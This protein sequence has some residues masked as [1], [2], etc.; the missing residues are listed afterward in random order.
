MYL[1]FIF[2]V[3]TSASKDSIPFLSVSDL[4]LTSAFSVQT[5]FGW[6][7]FCAGGADEFGPFEVLTHVIRVCEPLEVYDFRMLILLLKPPYA[8]PWRGLSH[9]FGPFPTL[10]HLFALIFFVFMSIVGE[11]TPF[12]VF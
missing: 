8:V 4:D 11:S 2:I 7:M 3:E 9:L 12:S 5:S 6:L 1:G 10:V